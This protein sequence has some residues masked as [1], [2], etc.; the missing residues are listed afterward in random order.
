[1]IDPLVEVANPKQAAIPVVC[2]LAGNPGVGA[3]TV[4]FQSFVA[5][6]DLPVIR[7][8]TTKAC[9]KVQQQL[10]AFCGS[11]QAA[12]TFARRPRAPAGL[13]PVTG[14]VSQKFKASRRGEVRAKLRLN[15][16]GRALLARS[17]SLPLQTH[18]QMQ[19]RQG[20]SL[21]ALFKTL[22]RLR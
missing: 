2:E 18:A 22:L 10:A 1:V 4:R 5:C 8:C 19:E 7:D 16:L 9:L 21:N 3:T 15:K 11:P 14:Q 13:V 20:S 17:T 6:G 12:V